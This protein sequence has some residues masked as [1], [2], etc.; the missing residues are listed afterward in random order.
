MIGGG[1]AYF[2]EALV[3]SGRIYIFRNQASVPWCCRL[4]GPEGAGGA[5]EPLGRESRSSFRTSALY[6]GP[7]G[8]RGTAWSRFSH[9]PAFGGPGG[10]RRTRGSAVQAS[11]TSRMPTANRERAATRQ[12]SEVGVR[13]GVAGQL[14]FE[15]PRGP[16]VRRCWSTGRTRAP[17]ARSAEG[18]PD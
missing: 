13:V 18:D 8:P 11:W 10:P 2:G 6:G 17:P 1:A 7:P 14:V 4:I 9:K 15:T 16:A 3:R 5:A 12:G